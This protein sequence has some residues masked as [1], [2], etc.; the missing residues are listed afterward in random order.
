MARLLWGGCETLAVAD[1]DPDG[2][3]T[4]NG[5][6]PTA[7]T[8][9]QSDGAGCYAYAN[10]GSARTIDVPFTNVNGTTYF[11]K[12]RFMFSA[13]PSVNV[14][15]MDVASGSGSTGSQQG[16]ILTT[17]GKLQG[18]NGG[19]TAVLT[20]GT[21]YC[22]ELSINRAVGTNLTAVVCRLNETNF[23][24]NSLTFANAP[25]R[26]RF[27]AAVV[28][29]APGS[30]IYFDDIALNDDT[31]SDNTSWPGMA[32]RII[33]LTPTTDSAIGANWKLGTGTAPGGAAHTAVANK[34]PIGVANGQ[35]GSDVKQIR[36]AVASNGT[37]ADDADF[38][39]QT[40]TA[41]G[42]PSGAT[43]KLLRSLA[44]FSD[45]SGVSAPATK[46]QIVSNPAEGSATNGAN[47]GSP[48]AG[49]WR[50]G[51]RVTRGPQTILPTVTPGTAP[52]VR[53]GRADNDAAT[54]LCC[55]VGIM[56]EYVPAVGPTPPTTGQLWPRGWK[57]TFSAL[58]G[59]LFPRRVIEP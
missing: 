20:P 5:T 3:P 53:V 1:A 54:L 25:T 45:S 36:D 7:D 6:A 22:V 56:V 13:N 34:P 28:A 14:T 19:Q 11:H 58:T 32:S 30:T 46:L 2:F 50:S 48:A 21:W 16:I 17:A 39:M 33:C 40:Y 4:V 51:W 59:Q 29:S 44:Y 26:F 31:G 42:L 10:P 35:A 57:D 43:V 8:T 52:V 55:F 18:P 23:D 9:H 12:A 41:A 38:T 27:G 37:S 47:T 49:T 24:T 15:I